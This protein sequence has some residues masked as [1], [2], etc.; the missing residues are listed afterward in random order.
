ME[1]ALV[2]DKAGQIDEGGAK[3]IE[4]ALKLLRESQTES[5]DGLHKK[6]I[7]LLESSFNAIPTRNPHIPTKIDTRGFF[8]QSSVSPATTVPTSWAPS[9]SSGVTSHPTFDFTFMRTG[10][11]SNASTTESVASSF[12]PG[13]AWTPTGLT[14]RFSSSP[15]QE[16]SKNDILAAFLSTIA[17]DQYSSTQSV[18]NSTVFSLHGD[19]P[20]QPGMI[21]PTIFDWSN[22]SSFSD[23]EAETKSVFEASSDV[24]PHTYLPMFLS[25]YSTDETS[26]VNKSF[27][28]K[29]QEPVFGFKENRFS[30][31]EHIHTAPNLFSE[32]T[33]WA[34]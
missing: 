2:Y 10:R 5:N 22:P 11:L 25:P 28:Y 3:S 18:E 7:T 19:S 17:D 31:N 9:M 20:T 1:I 26:P 27:E 34:V 14:D 6:R 4:T 23:E 29:Q 13:S 32:E 16:T 8:S 24:S 30:E 21:M 15:E 12:D 33:G